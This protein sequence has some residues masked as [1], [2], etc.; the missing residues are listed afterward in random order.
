MADTQCTTIQVQCND[1]RMFYFDLD[2]VVTV[3]FDAAQH[4]GEITAGDLYASADDKGRVKA[5]LPA[6][7]EPLATPGDSGDWDKGEFDA[8]FTGDDGVV[9]DPYLLGVISGWRVVD[10]P[11]QGPTDEDGGEVGLLRYM[12]HCRRDVDVRV[13]C[14]DIDGVDVDEIQLYSGYSSSTM[15]LGDDAFSRLNTP[16]S[17]RSVPNAVFDAPFDTRFSVLQGFCDTFGSVQPDSLLGSH[18][19]RLDMRFVDDNGALSHNPALVAG[20]HKLALSCGYE[21]YPITASAF[22]AAVHSGVPWYEVCGVLDIHCS[23]ERKKKLF[24]RPDIE[25]LFVVT[26]AIPNE[27]EQEKYAVGVAM[28]SQVAK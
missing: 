6:V 1:A 3:T 4:W 23:H 9:T 27:R 28:I 22:H 14:P 7:T 15:R 16:F 20:A 10:T 12:R 18:R 21:A 11:L 24:R 8:V 26:D 25:D 5:M 17:Q 13:L 2:D 19:V